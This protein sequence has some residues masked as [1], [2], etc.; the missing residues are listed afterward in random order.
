MHRGS[1]RPIGCIEIWK[2]RLGSPDRG[3]AADIGL[4]WTSLLQSPWARRVTR[5][6]ARERFPQC[7]V[8]MLCCFYSW[9]TAIPPSTSPPIGHIEQRLKR[10]ALRT[11]IQTQS[12]YLADSGKVCGTQ[13]L[14]LQSGD[15][16]QYLPHRVVRIK[17]TN[18]CKMLKIVC[19]TE[20]VFKRW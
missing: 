1:R 20:L 8:L 10:W 19:G 13:F 6:P 11:G 14:P 5:R 7:P 18:V 3:S 16:Y 2:L 9:G 15:W 17:W 12:H 4:K